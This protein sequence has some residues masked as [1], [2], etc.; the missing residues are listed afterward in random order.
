WPFRGE[1]TCCSNRTPLKQRPATGA[2]SAALPPPALPVE[3]GS[4]RGGRKRNI[5]P[6]GIRQRLSPRLSPRAPETSLADGHKAPRSLRSLS[7]HCLCRGYNRPEPQFLT[8]V[9]PP[10]GFRAWQSCTLPQQTSHKY[11]V[12]QVVLSPDGSLPPSLTVG[13]QAA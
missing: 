9:Q 2:K 13:W 10:C 4:G 7:T 8:V 6:N 11:L 12:Y 1:L 3:G 5:L